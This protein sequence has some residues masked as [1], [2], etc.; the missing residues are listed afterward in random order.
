MKGRVKAISLWCIVSLSSSF[1][2]VLIAESNVFTFP[3]ITSVSVK[4][5][6]PQ[7]NVFKHSGLHPNSRAITFSWAFPGSSA[8]KTGT[9][10]IYSLLGKTVAKI[11]VRKN[12]GTAPWQ[13]AS[14]QCRNGLFI[15]RIVYGDN[16]RN[17]KLMLWN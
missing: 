9:I 4:N 13:L 1:G 8:E 6:P 10:T 7:R 11:S 14:A 17:L 15:V 16:I 5:V 2:E 12:I 3:P